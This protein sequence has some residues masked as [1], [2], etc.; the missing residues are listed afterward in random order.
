MSIMDAVCF[1]GAA[2]CLLVVLVGFTDLFVDLWHGFLNGIAW[3]TERTVG[4]RSWRAE[5]EAE[6]L[7]RRIEELERWSKQ[8]EDLRMSGR[9]AMWNETFGW[10]ND[11]DV[12]PCGYV[13][14]CAVWCG[15]GHETGLCT[16]DPIVLR[17]PV[18]EIQNV[19]RSGMTPNEAT[20][21]RTR[22]VKGG[23][24]EV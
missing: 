17:L 19:R 4:R 20:Y 3:I 8:W 1:G 23:G 22:D 7:A 11:A 15:T 24:W 21:L 18:H 12:C 14:E 2:G 16:H 9:T 6:G 13:T 5:I 10:I